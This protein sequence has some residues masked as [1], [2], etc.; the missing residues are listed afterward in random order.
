M[1]AE[2]KDG[3]E[4]KDRG[5]QPLENGSYKDVK[6]RKSASGGWC[7]ARRGRIVLDTIVAVSGLG[8]ARIV[9]RKPVRWVRCLLTMV[10]N[11]QQSSY[12]DKRFF[13]RPGSTRYS[14]HRIFKKPFTSP[15][16]AKAREGQVPSSP[17]KDTL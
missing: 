17:S 3:Q 10:T 7:P 16:G 2:D 12:K 8:W 11:Q 4:G 6:K 15:Q 1:T 5:P 9:S 14:K 13:L